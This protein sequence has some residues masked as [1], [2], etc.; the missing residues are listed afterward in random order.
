MLSIA[1]RSLRRTPLFTA[2][3]LISTALGIAACTL[4]LGI[5]RAA[6]FHPGDFGAPDRIAVILETTS[7]DC[8]SCVDTFSRTTFESWQRAKPRSFSTLAA[9][10]SVSALLDESDDDGM[11][12]A[13]EITSGF[14]GTLGI[15]PVLGRDIDSDAS[16]TYA[17]QQALISY[18]LWQ[19]RFGGERS[20]I[21]TLLQVNGASYTIVGVMAR[22]FSYPGRTKLWLTAPAEPSTGSVDA[23]TLTAIGRLAPG[24]TIP[25]ARAELRSLSRQIRLAHATAD[26]DRGISVESLETTSHR[27]AP[28]GQW[29]LLGAVCFAFLIS[30]V[31][32]ANLYIV[33]ALSRTGETAIRAALGAGVRQVGAALLAESLLLALAGGVLGIL[34]AV[35]SAGV[36]SSFMLGRLEFPLELRIDG[37]LMA[38]AVGASCLTGVAFGLV[39]LLHFRRL[40]PASLLRSAGPGFTSGRKERDA[41]RLMVGVELSLVVV[42][43]VGA[44]LFSR[45]Y[46]YLETFDVGFD[47]SKVMTARPHLHGAEYQRPEQLLRLGNDLDSRIAR[48]PDA[49]NGAV[50]S[51]HFLPRKYHGARLREA[52]LTVEGYGEVTEDRAAPILSLDGTPG[53]LA[54]LGLHITKGRDFAASDDQ[55]SPRVVIVNEVA[56]D[57]YWPG[58]NALGKQLKLG[59]STSKAPWL[60]VVGVTDATIVPHAVGLGLA[61]NNPA[62]RWPQLFRPFAQAPSANLVV[63]ARARDEPERL[64]TPLRNVIEQSIGARTTAE[65]ETIR[66]TMKRSWVLP[67]LQLETLALVALSM[68]SIALGLVGVYA[69]VANVVQL[70][71]RELAIRIAVGAPRSSVVWLVLRDCVAVAA[72]G[73]VAGIAAAVIL[74]AFAGHTIFGITAAMRSGLL[75]GVDPADPTNYL[76]VL[77]LIA[78]VVLA[79]SLRPVRRALRIDPA[80]LSRP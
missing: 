36:V 62:R 77:L 74:V 61:L 44:V 70:R 35:Q 12:D 78:F 17:G 49:T 16:A 11:V 27:S 58:Q 45:S 29:L 34:L 4:A 57:E 52:V 22:G 14:A 8:P 5:V 80:V 9:F 43:S 54:T 51:T 31:N 59:P 53:T 10:R 41:R 63:A 48:I 66:S 73:I 2:V 60:T 68:T 28:S 30:C 64:V 50:W 33:R 1:V 24:A 75:F 21:G 67:L 18:G 39:P 20:A 46:I 3:V 72:G 23:R 15:H 40:D 79:A 71:T 65:Y 42:L 55:D 7:S 69:M 6:S 47:A 32:I 56:A 25:G 19:T 37:G 26:G 76:A 13:A 38:I